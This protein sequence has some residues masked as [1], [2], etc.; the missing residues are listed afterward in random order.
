MN[1]TR[2]ISVVL[3]LT[4]PNNEPAVTDTASFLVTAFAAIQDCNDRNGHITEAISSQALSGCPGMVFDTVLIDSQLRKDIAIKSVLNEYNKTHVFIGSSISATTLALSST[5]SALGMPTMTYSASSPLLSD[6]EIGGELFSRT[7]ASDTQRAVAMIQLLEELKY[8]QVAMIFQDSAYGI[9]F[10]DALREHV[11]R[12]QVELHPTAFVPTK[13]SIRYALEFARVNKMRV[14]VIIAVNNVHPMIFE[15]LD[16]LGMI[17]K[18]HLFVFG[19]IHVESFAKLKLSDA[20]K[21]LLARQMVGIETAWVD[22]GVKEYQNFAASWKTFQRVLPKVSEKLSRLGLQPITRMTVSKSSFEEYTLR[23][24]PVVYDAVVSVCRALCKTGNHESRET[25][26]KKTHT[27]IL[28]DEFPG[29]SGTIRYNR[30]D[31]NRDIATIRFA[32]KLF[33]YSPDGNVRSTLQHAHWT[34]NEWELGSDFPRVRSSIGFTEDYN[35]I[36]AG[37][38]ITSYVLSTLLILLTCFWMGWTWQKRRSRVISRSQPVMLIFFLVGI[39]LATISTYF[40]SPQNA[41]WYSNLSHWMQNFCCLAFYWFWSVGTSL[42]FGALLVKLWRIW[43]IFDNKKLAR[44]TFS[45]KRAC[46]VVAGIVLVDIIL[47]IVATIHSPLRF[48]RVVVQK[49]VFGNTLSS[50]GA[51]VSSDFEKIAIVLVSYQIFLFLGGVFITFK[52]RRFDTDYQESRY[53][54]ISIVSQCQIYLLGIPIAFVFAPENV[55][56]RF[57]VMYM[58]IWINNL[59]LLLVIYLP[60]HFATRNKNNATTG[61]RYVAYQKHVPKDNSSND[62]SSGYLTKRTKSIACQ[63]PQNNPASFTHKTNLVEVQ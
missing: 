60:K 15:V 10:R 42:S 21:H 41:Y 48:T 40:V 8:E 57:L 19:D 51:C 39:L 17:T 22:T 38:M 55:T 1:T 27:N 11:D 3:D 59:L 45:N 14:L 33:T 58:V 43:K 36:D 20:K 26:G 13:S 9:G 30:T 47:L 63:T 7:T 49:D 18:D 35:Y 34:R 4:S 50:Y 29:V 2:R 28:H 5:A 37:L 16:E 54:T 6:V 53:I 31:N 61:P 32:T 23:R 46:L 52:V 24:A 56:V 12:S 44:R 25:I 62:D